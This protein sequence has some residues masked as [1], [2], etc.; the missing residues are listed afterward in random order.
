MNLS[1]KIREI[2]RELDNPRFA[3]ETGFCTGRSTY[4]V[5]CECNLLKMVSID[6]NLDY[7]KHGKHMAK[8]LQSTFNCLEIIEGNSMK[9]LTDDFFNE[10]FPDGID[11]AVIDGDHTYKGC[12]SDISRIYKHITPNGVMIVDD[13]ESGPPLGMVLPGVVGAVDDFIKKN[14]ISNIVKWNSEGKGMAIFYG[15]DK[16]DEGKRQ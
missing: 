1:E 10:F 8:L 3:I 15:K 13:Y 7:S 6:I 14:S 4:S 5:L 2:C 9:V 12:F 16:I 11:I